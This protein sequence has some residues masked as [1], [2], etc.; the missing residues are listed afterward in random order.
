MASH[1]F[2]DWWNG[3][4]VRP[5][6][7]WDPTWY[8]GDLVF[9]VDPWVW[10]MLGGAVV[11]GTRRFGRTKWGWYALTFAATIAV[12]EACR[13]GVVPWWTLAAWLTGV[14]EIALLWWWGRWRAAPAIG[15]GLLASYLLVAAGVTERCGE[16]V[17]RL[18]NRQTEQRVAAVLPVAGVPWRRLQIVSAA[19]AGEDAAR[20]FPRPGRYS[21]WFG[22]VVSAAGSEPG[23][24]ADLR[25]RDDRP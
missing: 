14:L 8:Y 5:F 3:Y 13:R 16:E 20:Q 1:L 6:Y 25:R 24:G 7:P 22:R 18:A 19:S 10:L 2:M 23:G 15:W 4:G 21:Y 17:A 11:C 12:E 9:V